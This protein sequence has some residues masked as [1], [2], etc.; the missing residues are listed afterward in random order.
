M[1]NAFTPFPGEGESLQAFYLKA[2]EKTTKE[3]LTK[4][5]FEAFTHHRL[6][7]PAHWFEALTT[8]EYAIESKFDTLATE[9]FFTRIFKG[10]DCVASGNLNDED[11]HFFWE[12]INRVCDLLIPSFAEA[13]IEKALQ[14]L[15]PRRGYEDTSVI[16]PMLE[17]AAQRGNAT[18]QALWGYYLYGGFCGTP[19]R[20]K[21]MELLD[22]I[23]DPVGKQKAAIYKTHILLQEGKQE[24]A[25]TFF[26][27]A[28]E[29]SV[30]PEVQRMV[31]ELQ[32]FL[33]EYAKKPEEA[34]KYYKK[35]LQDDCAGF[36]MVR[37]GILNY[38]KLFEEATP[39]EGLRLMEESFMAGQ[40]NI[41]RSLFICY[42]NSGQEW[43]DNAR[44]IQ[45]LHKGYQYND[46]YSTYQLAYLYLFV[47]E[48]KDQEKG[49]WYLDEA[50]KQEYA[51]ALIC[52]AN[53][54]L[55]GN[56]LKQDAGKALEL[57]QQAMNGGSGYGAY[58]IG[59][60]YEQGLLTGENDYP[61]ALSYYEKAAA[62]NDIY[63]LEMAG[64]YHLMGYAGEVNTE[65]ALQY[66]S[67][68]VEMGSAYCM[69]ELA[70]MYQEGNGVEEDD[71][72]AFELIMKATE[73]EYAYAYFL[74][75]R[76]YRHGIG[77]EENPDEAIRFLQIAANNE[78]AKG[79]TELALCYE[80]GYGVEVN[81]KKALEYMLKAAEHDYAYAQYKV[82]CYYLYGIGEDVPSD[83]E[84]ALKWLSKAAESDYAYALLELGDYYLYDYGD[85]GETQKAYEY[86]MKAAGQNCVNQGLGVC[87]EYGI[88]V[89]EN[90]P[91]AFKYYLKAAED[92]YMRAMHCVARCYYHG[93][94]TKENH[95]EAF[96]WFNDAA[97]YEYSPS[98][99]YK[100]KMLMN[101]EGCTPN[102]EEG[103]TLLQLASDDDHANA[104]FEL[105]NCYLI[106]KGVEADEDKAMELFELAA[107]NGHEQ[108][109]KI[110][111]KRRRG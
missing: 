8:L 98:Q 41:V 18:A 58:R 40:H 80:E 82:G 78:V 67:R 51:D 19:D 76:C 70:F 68:G 42:F 108:A 89:E 44:A 96:R 1:N 109:L 25:N 87:L 23:T 46:A 10:Y 14:R 30:N 13:I 107:E 31:D 77:V 52:K 17:E 59:C 29:E 48:Y 37:L 27:A 5:V 43:Q 21:G 6:M 65:K 11:Y 81:G 110:T 71:A 92:G 7:Q 12:K 53:L 55:N 62:M 95:S 39:A 64:R 99:Y 50:V 3:K 104:Q 79:E 57:Y 100:G 103:I 9:T 20:E 90:E 60:I 75:G 97:A 16:L 15:H 86:Y 61:T 38:N 102:M 69:V 45:W 4:E 22:S 93:N 111:G 91:E 94:G 85:S 2:Y 105:A 84:E 73:N 101:G 54:Y 32:A 24:E 88:G 28:F 36:A 33:C 35:I 66:Y 47:D 49:L 26:Q 106:G 56:I 83:N 72:K 34:A 63:G 74:A